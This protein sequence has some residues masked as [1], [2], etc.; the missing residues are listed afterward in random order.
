MADQMFGVKAVCSS[1]RN[2]LISN[3]LLHRDH[4][5]GEGYYAQDIMTLSKLMRVSAEQSCCCPTAVLKCQPFAS[6]KF[7]ISMFTGASESIT[8]NHCTL[9]LTDQCLPSIT[10]LVPGIVL[11]NLV[12][13]DVVVREVLSKVWGY[14]HGGQ[15]FASV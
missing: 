4:Y 1:Q 11:A 14:P 8:T 2:R 15:L 10:V 9:N 13:S 12:M 5:L 7:G 6:S 3:S